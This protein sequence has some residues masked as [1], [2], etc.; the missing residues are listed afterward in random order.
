M[1][2]SAISPL[3]RVLRFCAILAACLVAAPAAA[4]Q[5]DREKPIH[6][7][8]DRMTVDDAKQVAVFEGNVK[9]TQGT[10]SIRADKIVVR[11][12]ADGFQHGTAYGRPAIFRQKR[13]GADEYIEGFGE[14]MEYDGRADKIE[15]FTEARIM[16]G[17]DEVRGSYIS[18]NAVTEFFKVEGGSP[19][20]PEGRVRAVLQPK[21][22]Q[23]PAPKPPLA[24]KPSGSLGQ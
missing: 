2:P 19:Q 21:A 18:Y 6:L 23:E 1:T 20:K 5:A 16:R 22:K 14:R 12:D 9:L 3:R 24:I 4:E 8:A 17:Q 10:M 13:E 11:Q 7:E 15:L